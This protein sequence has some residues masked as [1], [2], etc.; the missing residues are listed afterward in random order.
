MLSHDQ[1]QVAVAA[2]KRQFDL[3][4][5]KY[6]DLKACLVL[7]LPGGQ[8]E[9]DSSP[10]QILS[11]FPAMIVDDSAKTSALDIMYR[12]KTL[13][14]QAKVGSETE[15]LINQLDQIT[16]WL[17]FDEKCQIEIRFKDLNYDLVWKLQADDLV[18][19]TLTLQN[20]ASI[21]IVLG[22]LSR[23]ISYAQT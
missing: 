15:Q 11:K 10:K 23:F 5:Q 12:L 13:E 9:I 16:T 6:P 21:R 3:I 2:G 8:T 18:D 4:R 19:R 14:R 22:I 7:S 1:L 20:K 17:K